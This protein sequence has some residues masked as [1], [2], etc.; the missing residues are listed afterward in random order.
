[1]FRKG[2]LLITVLSAIFSALFS[3]LVDIHNF[4]N[5][6]TMISI[7]CLMMYFILFMAFFGSIYDI[8][9]KVKIK[10]NKYLLG[11][12]ISGIIAYTALIRLTTNFNMFLDFV[13]VIALVCAILLGNKGSQYERGLTSEED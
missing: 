12:S 6:S 4:G 7:V 3:W 1:M 13:F 9:H 5:N 2:A 11:A 10:A 8:F